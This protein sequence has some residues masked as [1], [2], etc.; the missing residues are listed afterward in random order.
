[1]SSLEEL[2]ADFSLV[3]T[4]KPVET[5]P[6]VQPEDGKCKNCMGTHFWRPR[7]GSQLFCMACNPPAIPGLIGQE[8]GGSVQIDVQV[9]R[10]VIDRRYYTLD[11]KCP[12][13]RGRLITETTWS[14]GEC[15]LK[16]WTCGE[17][18]GNE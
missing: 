8:F 2:L 3:A 15:E 14:T 1:M 17:I 9:V 13:C 11:E 12:S 7:R 10:E 4:P 16:C 18:R 6:I 5:T